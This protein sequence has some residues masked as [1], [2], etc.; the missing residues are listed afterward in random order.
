MT[1]P[2]TNCRNDCM[3]MPTTNRRNC[4]VNDRF[5]S[6]I[7]V[8]P[9]TKQNH[10][11]SIHEL[12]LSSEAVSSVAI[13]PFDSSTCMMHYSHSNIPMNYQNLPKNDDDIHYMKPKS[14]IFANFSF[15]RYAAMDLEDLAIKSI[16][17]KY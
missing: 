8:P 6:S 14:F 15:F 13:S 2:K 12:S 11:G 3:T 4:V 5:V 7:Y 9:T 1:M 17:I 16:I 10:H